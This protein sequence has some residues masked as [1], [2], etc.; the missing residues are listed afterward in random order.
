MAAL[1]VVFHRK[2]FGASQTGMRQNF[3][4][5]QCFYR[6]FNSIQHQSKEDAA[7]EEQVE[8]SKHPV[9]HFT[10]SRKNLPHIGEEGLVHDITA[11]QSPAL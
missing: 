3:L 10:L 8:M 5:F 11:H 1:T 2:E 7:K 9:E 6:Y 4:F